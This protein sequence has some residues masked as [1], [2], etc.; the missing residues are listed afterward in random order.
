MCWRGSYNLRSKA[1]VRAEA[2]ADII[3]ENA[4]CVLGCSP[5]D[6]GFLRQQPAHSFT[7]TALFWGPYLVLVK[8]PL[9]PVARSATE[10]G[11]GHLLGLLQGSE[12]QE[13]TV[14]GLFLGPPRVRNG[15]QRTAVWCSG[16]MNLQS[17][18]PC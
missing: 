1:D 4:E 8:L 17:D 5:R 13:I 16:T 18:S 9:V 2:G 3:W 11:G 14:P 7:P 10:P 12:A 6:L 15:G